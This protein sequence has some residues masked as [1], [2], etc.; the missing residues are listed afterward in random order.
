ML[1]LSRKVGESIVIADNIRIM[2]TAI[3]G[4]KVKIGVDAP[5]EVSVNRLEVQESI[6]AKKPVKT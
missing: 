4:D 6:N 2:V 5:R 3:Q 1:V